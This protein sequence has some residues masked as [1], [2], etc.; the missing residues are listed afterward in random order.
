MDYKVQFGDTITDA[1]LNPTGVISN[2]ES[3]LDLNDFDT[4]T[5]DLQ[6]GDLVEIADDAQT[7]LEAVR[8]LKTY[9]G[10]NGSSETTYGLI[11]EIFIKLLSA[12]PNIK[13]VVIPPN[14]V[15]LNQ[16]YKVGFGESIGDVVLNSTGNIDNWEQIL[17]ANNFDWI[18]VLTAGELVAIPPGV[19]NELNALRA[20]TTYPANN[21]VEGDVYELISA[22]FELMDGSNDWILFTS[23]WRDIGHWYDTSFWID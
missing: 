17:N 19:Q 14:V 16:Y 6:A 9:P 13:A 22:I 2:W 7:D 10:C 23:F 12:N 20:L 4:W 8:A 21:S 5:P 3:I 11:N 15:D 18:P 1:V